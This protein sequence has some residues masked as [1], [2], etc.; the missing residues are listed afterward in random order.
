MPTSLLEK[1]LCL[2]ILLVYWIAGALYA[3]YTPAWQTPDEPAHYNYI[4]QVVAA[5][6]CPRIEA[7]DWSSEYLAELT[8]GRFAPDLLGQLESIQYEDH[9]PPLYYLLASL[10]YRLT[11]GDLISL[12]FFSLALGAGVVF[13]SYLGQPP[14]SARSAAGGAGRDGAGRLSA[15][16]PAH[17]G[18]RQ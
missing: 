12:R 13:L 17:A 18:R 1:R 9:H 14:R 6:C 3:I 5:G 11:D 4:R 10:I 15:A 16:A 8:S 7:G 2:T